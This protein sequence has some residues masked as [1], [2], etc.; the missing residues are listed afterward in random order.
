MP[1]RK[2]PQAEPA[3]A[4]NDPASDQD[5]SEYEE[6]DPEPPSK[7]QTPTRKGGD[8]HAARQKALAVLKE[9]TEMKK[10]QAEVARLKKETER[11]LLEAERIQLTKQLAEARRI[12]EEVATK[13]TKP[14]K[15]KAP[16][17]PPS[18]SETSSSEEEAPPPK[19]R[20]RTPAP[21]PTIIDDQAAVRLAYQQRID[22]LRQNLV[23]QAFGL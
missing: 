16:P 22:A 10:K 19:P 20:K 18:D 1:P 5:D 7:I 6:H 2:K 14:K 11:E 8:I 15:T 13:K 3:P 17:P 23:R 12:K 21:R 9:R 4:L